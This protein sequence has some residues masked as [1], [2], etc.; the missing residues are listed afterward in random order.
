MLLNDLPEAVPGG[1]MTVKLVAGDKSMEIMKWD[2]PKLQVNT[3]ME[4]PVTAPV[5]LP[6]WNTKR[7]KLVVEVEGKPEYSSEYTFLYQQRY[8]P[9][10][11]LPVL[12]Q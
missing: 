4:G 6:A 7:I 1:K 9:G 3:N 10:R 12:N 11:S 2:Y 5:K 8:R